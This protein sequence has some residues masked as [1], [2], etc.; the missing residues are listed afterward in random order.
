MLRG[1]CITRPHAS[2]NDSQD[3]LI[4]CQHLIMIGSGIHCQSD[5]GT[6]S[7]RVPPH[8]PAPNRT[9]RCR[10]PSARGLVTQG[11]TRP[12]VAAGT[13][14]RRQIV[15]PAEDGVGDCD[16]YTAFWRMVRGIDRRVADG[17]GWVVNMALDNPYT[18]AASSPR[19]PSPSIYA[20]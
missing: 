3:R 10:H 17:G 5:T 11:V 1:G 19:P 2:A 14:R 18:A 4:R 13:R 12:C 15:A 16:G 7:N 20:P 6:R 9:T 8:A